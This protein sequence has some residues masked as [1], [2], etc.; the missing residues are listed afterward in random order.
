MFNH[1]LVIQVFKHFLSQLLSPPPLFIS[2][3]SVTAVDI[4]Y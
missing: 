3:I 2:V 1:M 4:L